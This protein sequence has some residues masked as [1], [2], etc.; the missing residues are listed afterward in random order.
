LK[1][2][3]LPRVVKAEASRQTTN[4]A[5]E[6]LMGRRRRRASAY[7]FVV[8]ALIFVV[9]MFW[10][11]IVVTVW[12]SFTNSNGL[13]ASKY[14]GF[15]NYRAMFQDPQLSTNVYNTLIWAVAMVV[16]P[17]GL[18]LAAA[19]ALRKRKGK[20]LFQTVFYLPY[21]IGFVTTGVIWSFLFGTSG[22]TVLFQA[23]GLHYLASL[24]WLNSVPLNT[25]SMIV[26]STWQIVGVDMLLFFVG[27]DTMDREVV[28]AAGLDGAH[29]WS[30]FRH[31]TIPS[32]TPMTRVIVAISIVNALQA[33][34]LI[35][36]MTQG[37]PYGSSST[38]AVW[39]YQQ[40]FQFFKMG[41]GAAIA[42][43]LTIFVL[44]ASV[45][46]LR[47]SLREVRV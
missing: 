30:M 28:E 16:L 14:V 20:G 36:V 15:A 23:L 6:G 21:A 2:V 3:S 40:S 35:W 32:L 34:N 5:R 22:F 25:Y 1:T 18:G 42:V 43:V 39:T 24:Q 10:Y 17:V 44:L 4:G 26:A 31:I 9:G 7:L 29:G 37:G 27:L 19:L 47:R 41:Y 12:T 8:P 11:S 46:Y 45:G 13:S 38:F 33:F